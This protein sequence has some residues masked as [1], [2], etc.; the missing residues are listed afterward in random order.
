MELE[1]IE[2]L[3]EYCESAGMDLSKGWRVCTDT[4]EKHLY[5]ISLNHLPGLKDYLYTTGEYYLYIIVHN[6][7]P[8][9]CIKLFNI[10]MRD[11][12]APVATATD[13]ATAT[14]VR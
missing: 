5:G 6:G 7:N 4:G 3:V 10:L 11:M 9:N 8:D 14:D 2:G 13:L 1:N 12:S